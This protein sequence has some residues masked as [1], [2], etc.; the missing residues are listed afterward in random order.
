MIYDTLAHASSYHSL[1]PRFQAALEYLRTFDPS[2]P[3][4]KVPVQGDDVYAVVQ[5]YIPTPASERPF[6]AHRKYADIQYVV[7]GEELIQYCPLAALAETK[8][9][10][11]ANDFALYKGPDDF[12]LFMTAGTFAILLPQDGHKPGC[13]WRD[14]GKVKK[15]VMK[16]R[17]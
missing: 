15:V 17:V 16:V 14:A 3:D 10:V 5:S 4:G 2:T 12:P 6:E 9:Y 13:L 1:S 7:S 11:D 8:A